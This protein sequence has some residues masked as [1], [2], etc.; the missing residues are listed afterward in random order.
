MA[1]T[2]IKAISNTNNENNGTCV[3]FYYAHFK[4]LISSAV[5]LPLELLK[6]KST[7]SRNNNFRSQTH[8]YQVTFPTFVTII[9]DKY[10]NT[11]NG[12]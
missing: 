9:K 2:L 11:V 4:L 8:I 10:R 5:C 12:V 6:R 7:N 1:V 3:L